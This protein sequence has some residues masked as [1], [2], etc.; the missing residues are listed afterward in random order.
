MTFACGLLAFGTSC[1][2]HKR[3]SN[4][5]V[6]TNNEVR[7]LQAENNDLQEEINQ[8]NQQNLALR[9]HPAIRKGIGA[10]EQQVHL[11]EKE[12]ATLTEKK[13]VLEAEVATLRKDLEDYRATNR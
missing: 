2:E 4:Q 12:V 6:E 1:Q 8:I 5:I 11:F 3:L 10:F 9:S 13:N 7:Q